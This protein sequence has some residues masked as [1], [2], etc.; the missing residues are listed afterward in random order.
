MINEFIMRKISYLLLVLVS[1]VLLAWQLPKLFRMATDERVSYPFTYYSCVI[2][3]FCRVEASEQA[4]KRLDRQGRDYS[5]A[6]F[7]SILPMFNYRQL[8]KDGRLPDSLRGVP[9]SAKM[10]SHHSFFHRYR[11]ADWQRPAIALYPLFESMSGKVDLEMPNG[12]FQLKDSLVFFVPGSNSIDHDKSHQFNDVLQRRGFRA[13]ARLVAGTPSARKAYDEGY[14]VVDDKH[15]VFHMKMV[16]GKPFIKNTAI[17]TALQVKQIIT[18]EFSDRRFYGFL[19]DKEDQMYIIT[20]EGYRLQKVE[21]PPFRLA[22][23]QLFV[24]ANLFYWNVQVTSAEGQTIYALD[25]KTLQK[26]DEVSY[27]RLEG[28][29]T[30]WMPWLFPF[31]VSFESSFTQFVAPEIEFTGWRFLP[32]SLV[33]GLMALLVM[34]RSKRDYPS[35]LWVIV[36]GLYGFIAYLLLRKK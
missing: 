10:I 19:F 16:N 4:V 3:D 21:I 36:T 11:P 31:V 22:D 17:D 33:L 7:D 28:G 5:E 13:P 8:V 25:A 18:T 2:N 26:V 15:Q 12:V 35:V 29:K 9:V 27:P 23:C 14:F 30:H 6:E 34:P 1:T 24:M 32:L 20:T